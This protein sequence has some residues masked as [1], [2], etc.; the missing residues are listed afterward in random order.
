MFLK[1]PVLKFV[2]KL[3]IIFVLSVLTGFFTFRVLSPQDKLLFP[4]SDFE[5]GSLEN[6]TA[7]GAAFQ[8]QPTF[9]DN[10]LKRGRTRPTEIQGNFWIGTYENRPS[11][12]SAEGMSQSDGPM[13]R[14]ISTPFTLQGSKIG[15]LAGAGNN[16]NDTTITL[17]I[18]GK[19]VLTHTPSALVLNEETLQPVVWDV[20][21]WK[22][23]KARIII[24]DQSFGHWGHINADNFRYQ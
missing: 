10:P 5:K 20:Q 21:Q 19:T 4:N 12:D 8:N 9:G 14:L 23:K 22:G 7:E 2:I 15:F 11:A 24:T 16:T 13:G 18:D 6:W 3:C 1:S 17:V